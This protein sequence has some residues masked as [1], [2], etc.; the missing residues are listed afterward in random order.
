MRI[1]RAFSLILAVITVVLML[2][3]CHGAKVERVAFQVPEEFD[4]SRTYELSFWAKND[5]NTDQVNA[6]HKAI[7]DFEALYPNIKVKMKPYTDYGRIY[8]DV[9]T[10]I[11]TGTTPNICIT[12]PDHIA[13]YNEGA[14]MVVALGSLMDDARYGLG[15]SEIRFDAPT[16]DEM[17]PKFLEECKLDGDYFAMPFVRSTEA[18]YVNKTYVEKLGF[19]LPDVL[20]WDFVWEVAEAAMKKDAE[21]T[22]A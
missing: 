1:T 10:N 21:G 12:Y 16:R 14:N 3:G 4:T 11:S 17:I 20:T 2:A 19:T 13:T 5:T 18:C 8:Q 9:I 7:A 22:D 6:Y 15:G